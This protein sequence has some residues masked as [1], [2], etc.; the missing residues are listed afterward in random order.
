[1]RKSVS[2]AMFETAMLKV[3]AEEAML[4]PQAPKPVETVTPEQHA[5]KARQDNINGWQGLHERYKREAAEGDA[6][7]FGKSSSS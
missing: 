1:V 2:R 4:N 3:Q 7:R 5:A 6:R